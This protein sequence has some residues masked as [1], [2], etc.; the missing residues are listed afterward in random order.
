MSQS[1]NAG[2]DWSPPVRVHDGPVYYEHAL[3]VGANGFGRVVW[4]E[5]SANINSLWTAH[6]DPAANAPAGVAMVRMGSDP[7]ER[8][9]KLSIDAAGAGLIAWVQDDDTGNDSVW[10]VSF[11]GATLTT[12]Q[13]LD[14]YAADTAG[15]VDV[16]IAATGGRGLAVWYQRNG[17]SSADLY[18]ADWVAGEGWK[19]PARVLNASWVSSPAVVLDRCGQRHRRLHP[20]DHRLQVERHRNR[21]GPLAA[22]GRP[23]SRWR[24]PTRPLAAPIRIRSPTW[25]WTA[26]ATST[27]SG[28]ARPAP[29]PTW[30]A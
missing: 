25:G 6:H 18:A 30:P 14:N 19:A 16:A 29:R 7:Y 26:P 10:G 3:A 8:Y 24:P 27:P 5:S 21:A 13:L 28:A 17:T 22:A 23:P 12:P 20:A 4:Q 1:S 9:P 15:E 11:T 2:V